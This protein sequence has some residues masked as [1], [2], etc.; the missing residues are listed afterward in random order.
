M[1]RGGDWVDHPDGGF[2]GQGQR[3]GARFRIDMLGWETLA[4]GLNSSWVGAGGVVWLDRF[5]HDSVRAEPT[6]MLS[7]GVV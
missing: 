7:I 6:P 1:D 2:D 5:A 3:L 4:V